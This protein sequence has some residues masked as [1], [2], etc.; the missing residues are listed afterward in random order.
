MGT[1]YKGS[2][3]KAEADLHS[4]LSPSSLLFILFVLEQFL[5]TH[6][7]HLTF[8]IF[9]NLINQ[10]FINFNMHAYVQVFSNDV[11]GINDDDNDDNDDDGGGG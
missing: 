9:F 7:P 3:H 2:I 11:Y 10:Y 1:V 6:S 5:T 8:I 4:I